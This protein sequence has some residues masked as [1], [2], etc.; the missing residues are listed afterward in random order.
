MPDFDDGDRDRRDADQR[1]GDKERAWAKWERQQYQY[2]KHRAER[3][4][5]VVCPECAGGTLYYGCDRCNGEGV[6]A[7]TEGE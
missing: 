5:M 1:H 6:I 2:S 3:L 7:R 4:G